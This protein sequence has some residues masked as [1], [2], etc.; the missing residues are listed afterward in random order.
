[1]EQHVTLTFFTLKD[2]VS[3]VKQRDISVVRCEAIQQDKGMGQGAP[4]AMR[5]YRLILTALDAS[6]VLACTIQIASVWSIFAGDQPHHAE[7]I[8]KAEQILARHLAGLEIDVRP[9]IYHH[10]SDGLATTGIWRFDENGR[11]LPRIAEVVEA[12]E[13]HPDCQD[14]QEAGNCKDLPALIEGEGSRYQ[15]STFFCC[16]YDNDAT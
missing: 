15:R 8:K 10:D 5:Q 16:L 13:L 12:K 2:F 7:N 3:E 6:T 14:C 1:M 9:G 11:L 4:S